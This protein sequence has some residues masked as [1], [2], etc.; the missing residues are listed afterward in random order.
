MFLSGPFSLKLAMPA[1]FHFKG[2][3]GVLR[4]HHAFDTGA[5]VVWD[6]FRKCHGNFVHS[7]HGPL[8]V[9]VYFARRRQER[10]EKAPPSTMSNDGA[11]SNPSEG[12][13]KGKRKSTSEVEQNR[14]VSSP[15]MTKETNELAY[16]CP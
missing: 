14:T 16:V 11:S 15:G 13:G 2:V 10:G 6:T 7:I 12:K 9:F 8:P 3:G 4:P 5:I 1:Y